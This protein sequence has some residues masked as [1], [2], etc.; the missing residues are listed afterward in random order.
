MSSRVPTLAPSTRANRHLCF[1]VGGE[2]YGVPILQ[3]SEIQAYTAPTPMPRMPGHVRGVQN[4]R[5]AIVPI[6]D[7]RLRLGLPPAPVGPKTVIV[8]LA[9]DA[10]TFGVVVDGA[11]RVVDVA[12][13]SVGVPPKLAG[14]GEAPFVT[15]LA[16][17][18]HGIL[19]LLDAAALP[20]LDLDEPAEALETNQRSAA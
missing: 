11:S 9:S 16:R 3:V 4:L 6:V 15:G 1:H 13:E 10:R 18:S 19:L 7:L 17:T 2:Q 12:P 14:A 8:F 5:G 20:G